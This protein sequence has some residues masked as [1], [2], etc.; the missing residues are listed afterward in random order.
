MLCEDV[1][2]DL[3]VKII[4]NGSLNRPVRERLLLKKDCYMNS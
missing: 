2:Y 3:F 1:V 4:F